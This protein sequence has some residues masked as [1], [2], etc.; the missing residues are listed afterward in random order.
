V[1]K[2]EKIIIGIENIEY[3]LFTMLTLSENFKYL[4]L[5]VF[6]KSILAS[7]STL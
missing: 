2:R 3:F 7:G 4:R 5:F 1:L 6:E